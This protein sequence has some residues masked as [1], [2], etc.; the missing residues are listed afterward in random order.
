MGVISNS[1]GSNDAFDVP[2][3]TNEELAQ[4]SWILLRPGFMI[5]LFVL[6][7]A[8]DIWIFRRCSLKYSVV[9]GLAKD[10]LVS[11]YRLTCL[12]LVSGTLLSCA[13]IIVVSQSPSPL[14]LWNILFFYALAF[15]GLFVWLPPS[16]A[17]QM[18][19]R[20]PLGRSLWRCVV[21][22]QSM[23]I[24]FVQVLVADGLCS[25]AK[26]FFDLALGACVVVGS[27][28][29]FGFDSSPEPSLTGITLTSPLPPPTSVPRSQLGTALEKCTASSTPFLFQTIP[30]IIRA[31]QCI[32]TSKHSG[33]AW[34]SFLQ[35][36]NLAKYCS[37]FP[38]VFF[39]LCYLKAGLQPWLVLSA[40]DF[41]VMW[42]LAAIVN[43]VFSFMWDLVMDWGLLQPGPGRKLQLSTGLRPVLLFRS[44]WGFYHFAIVCNLLGRALWSLRWSI[45]ANDLLGNFLLGTLQQTLEVL[46]RIL[47]NTIRVEWEIVKRGIHRDESSLQV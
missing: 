24:P 3:G 44:D 14:A 31:R 5:S 15:L 19:W 18:R 11:P 1:S 30:F 43:A 40:Q 13:R 38:V 27:T 6:G 9:L 47:W 29:N 32:I 34:S 20:H 39:S 16:L 7:W 36:I 10:E 26:V 28:G 17:R 22:V 12:A 42:A 4:A 2:W 45:S 21:P 8:V 33:D 46:R 23:E 41:E 35:K 25:L 37:T